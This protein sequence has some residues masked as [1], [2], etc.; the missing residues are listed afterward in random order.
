MRGLLVIRYNGQ[1]LEPT[2]D[3]QTAESEASEASSSGFIW[4]HGV[5]IAVGAVLVLMITITIVVIAVLA[6]KRG[7]KANPHQGTVQV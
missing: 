5:L 3:F 1:V 4:W 7:R 6:S 2:G